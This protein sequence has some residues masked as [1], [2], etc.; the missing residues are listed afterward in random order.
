MLQTTK[1]KQSKTS[2]IQNFNFVS[3]RTTNVSR[4]YHRNDPIQKVEVYLQAQDFSEIQDH[5]KINTQANIRP[6]LSHH[7][8][9]K[10]NSKN[11]YG[12]QF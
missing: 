7:L 9:S 4:K 12:Y 8:G 11:N 10:R 2:S 5:S 1:N 3:K 6:T